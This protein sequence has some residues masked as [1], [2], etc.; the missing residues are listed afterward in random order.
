M[1]ISLE[2]RFKI[3]DMVTLTNPSGD[4][5]GKLGDRGIITKIDHRGANGPR[6]PLLYVELVS[7]EDFGVKCSRFASRWELIQSDWDE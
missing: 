5:W 7:G 1:T 6:D 4:Q 2:N 3:G